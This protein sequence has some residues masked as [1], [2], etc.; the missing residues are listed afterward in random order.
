M[1]RRIAF[2]VGLGWACT[3]NSIPWQGLRYEGRKLKFLLLKHDYL[4]GGQRVEV[5]C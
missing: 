1:E 3:A 5:D 2:L 4:Y